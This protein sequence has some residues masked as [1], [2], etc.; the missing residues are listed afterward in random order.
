ML[1]AAVH[2]IRILNLTLLTC[3]STCIVQLNTFIN[4]LLFLAIIFSYSFRALLLYEHLVVVVL[5][6]HL[7]WSEG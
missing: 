1:D 7:S 6:S 3:L 2:F 5:E 4:L